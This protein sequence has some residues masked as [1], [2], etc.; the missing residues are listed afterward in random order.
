MKKAILTLALAAVA[1]SSM[2][3]FV[4]G[5]VFASTD[6][7]APLAVQSETA[8]AAITGADVQAKGEQFVYAQEF[9]A[10]IKY[11]DEVIAANPN[12]A[13]AYFFRALGK[14][15]VATTEDDAV[16][17]DLNKA[18]ELNPQYAD[19]YTGRAMVATNNG[20][21]QSAL[22]D[23]SSV[24]A[25]QPDNLQALGSRMDLHE[26]L[27]DWNGFEAD[28]NH[29]ISIAPENPQGYYYRA[30]ARVQKGDIANAIS[31]LEKTSQLLVAE[32]AN[33]QEV[34]KLIA[35]LKNGESIG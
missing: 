10:L 33:D 8:S 23:W 28:C 11:C 2:S 35:R 16:L 9:D 31:D 25:I 13:E 20:D 18:I 4:Y 19:A 17:A 22:R 21:Y 34:Q 27:Q 29:L 12:L 30:M 5:P 3:G 15:S 7:K 14:Y 1:S 26:Y 32:G 6:S 24:L